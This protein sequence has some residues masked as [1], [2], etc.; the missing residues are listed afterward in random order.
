MANLS[1][2][3][4]ACDLY[5]NNGFQSILGV[6]ES[7]DIVSQIK[8]CKAKIRLY[9]RAIWP[10]ACKTFFMLNSAEHEIS[11]LNKSI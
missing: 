1:R 6:L 4:P 3:R 5:R 7:C 9:Y 2:T 8:E 11:M 10:R